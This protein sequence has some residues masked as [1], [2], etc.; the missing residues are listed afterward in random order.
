MQPSIFNVR[1]PLGSG[2][3]FLLNT[4]TEAQMVV[5]D[6]VIA[7]LDR[8]KAGSAPAGLDPQEREAVAVL[9]EN[10]FLVADRQEDL[11][12]LEGQFREFREDASQL[13]LTIL[14]TLQCNFACDYCYQG[15]HGQPA[16]PSQK[17][18]LDT[19]GAVAEWIG[20]Q[21]DAVQP[22]RLVLTFF[23]GEPLLN[24]PAMFAI[25]EAA[26]RHTRA[27]GVTQIVTVIT[28]GL[29]L[30]PEIV[31][32]LLPLGLAGVKVT[33][34]GDRATH[35]RMR[36]LRGGQGTFDRIIANVRRASGKVPIAIGGNFDA[37]SVESYPALLDFLTSQEFAQRI[38][39][40]SFKPVIR[41]AS[42]PQPAGV[43]PLTPVG[44]GG[45]PTGGACVTAGG[46]G[47]SV[48]DSCHF[49]DDPMSFLREETVRRGLPTPDGVH[50]GPCELYRRH[51]HTIGP[52]GSLYAC[53]GFTG[54]N[55][56][57]VGHIARPPEG[58]QKAAAST[59]DQLAP[60]RQCGD[61]SFIPVCGGGCAVASRAELGDMGAPSC[62]KRSMESA[63]VSLAES[64]ASVP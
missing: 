6:D 54:D 42:P 57:A 52:D 18:T 16:D 64:T 50:M 55:A 40:V 13:R 28:N 15:D 25:A 38:S 46:S 24:T 41:P 35:D 8:L 27:R 61:C 60:W 30:S 53:P 5:S 48:C 29:L 44:A 14:T 7:F 31:D 63:L 34:D 51:S 17:M 43:I 45:A 32:R 9:Q 58:R 37:A 21:L 26:W 56:L 39:K 10:G 23:G 47:G 59:F 22:Q 12:R 36:P 62:H 19:A 49:V 33:L 3:V 1:V 11:A 2:D 20:R 4:L